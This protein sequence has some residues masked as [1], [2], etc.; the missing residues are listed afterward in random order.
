MHVSGNTV[1]TRTG[2]L[3]VCGGVPLNQWVKEGH[4]NGSSVHVLPSDD[5]LVSMGRDLLGIS[6]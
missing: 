6:P 1:Y 3:S 4:D 2:Q 5:T